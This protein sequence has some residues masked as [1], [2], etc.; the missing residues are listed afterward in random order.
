MASKLASSAGRSKAKSIKERANKSLKVLDGSH[1]EVV[2]E[3]T[4]DII[5]EDVDGRKYLDFSCGNYNVLGYNHPEIVRAIIDTARRVDHVPLA[6]SIAE[7]VVDHAERLKSITPGLGRGKVAYGC[8]GTESVE[9]AAKLAVGYTRRPVLIAYR[10][11]H[12]GRGPATIGLTADVAKS[13]SDYPYFANAVHV[14]FPYCY[15]CPFEH[16]RSS[17]C[18]L[19]CFSYL[20]ETLDTVVPSDSV[21]G[22]LIEP[23]QG[24]NGYVVPPQE[25]MRRL[26]K[27]CR[28]FG[29][30]LIDDEVLLNMG[31][32]G[33]MLS[34]E[35]FGVKPDIVALGK[36]LGFG[37]PLSA[38]VAHDVM[39][40]R[41]SQARNFSTAAAN[42]LAIAASIRGMEII[43]RDK[44]LDN[45]IRLGASFRKR[46]EKGAAKH[47]FVGEVRGIG[48]C[49]GI[50]FVQDRE[51]KT[52]APDIAARMVRIAYR[53]GLLLIRTGT[54][55]N[56]VRISPPLI[57]TKAIAEKGAQIICDCLEKS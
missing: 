9:F 38:I 14:P 17:G 44:L 6:N 5:I 32:T 40:D 46:I 7:L 54:Y 13:K 18:S 55:G 3:R 53:K 51:S 31:S 35:H 33:R 41:W 29:I 57:T 22:I 4:H 19:E 2:V 16:C 36:A 12:H 21:A 52:P 49:V 23:V 28:E 1:E 26:G 34:I 27:L 39:I 11:G 56:I 47:D 10:G 37:L 15:R 43:R 8:S 42:H 48:L 20:Q 24:W 45:A 30:L 50:E 25:Y